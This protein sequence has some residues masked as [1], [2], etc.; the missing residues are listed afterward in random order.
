MWRGGMLTLFGYAYANRVLAKVT[1]LLQLFTISDRP[2]AVP[3][4]KSKMLDG[5]FTWAKGLPLSV[6]K[7]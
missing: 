5:C 4:E 6:G 3:S 7:S 1:E 2:L